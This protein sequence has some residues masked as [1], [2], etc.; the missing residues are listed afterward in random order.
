MPKILECNATV[1]AYNADNKC[2]AFAITVGG[3]GNCPMCDTGIIQSQK[4]GI[5]NVIGGV[6]ACKEEDCQFNNSLE[7]SANG[8]KVKL[9]TSH[10]DCATFKQK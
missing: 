2:H 10:A 4:G 1:C 7:C 8:I 5:P 6:G 3:G 9:H